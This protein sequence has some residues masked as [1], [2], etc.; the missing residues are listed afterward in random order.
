MQNG[1]VSFW[2]RGVGYSYLDHFIPVAI[3]WPSLT[4]ATGI[5]TAQPQITPVY[6]RRGV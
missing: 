1:S 6:S 5:K 2:P 4:Y 3:N